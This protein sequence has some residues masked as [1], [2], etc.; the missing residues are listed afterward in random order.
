MIICTDGR[1][2]R[3]TARPCK[4]GVHYPLIESGIGSD[5]C[6]DIGDEGAVTGDRV[7]SCIFVDGGYSIEEVVIGA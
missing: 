2:I 1:V 4:N 3:S 7:V 5:L 6:I